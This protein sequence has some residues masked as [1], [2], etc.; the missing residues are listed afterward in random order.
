MTKPKTN[1]KHPGGRP[2]EYDEH[3]LKTARQYIL[4]GYSNVG[5]VIPTI[6][7]LA[8]ILVKSKQTL[9]DWGKQHPEFLDALEELKGKQA[10][11][12]Q[13]Y[14]LMGKFAPVITKLML[15]AN[16]GMK[17]KTEQDIT[18]QGEKIQG[19][20]VELVRAERDD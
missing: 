13:N 8:E 10:R 1:G 11:L 3:H 12:L 5:D 7:G 6:E 14:G 4:I 18:S 20:T 16:H 9:L 2:S 17:E 15:S 19:I